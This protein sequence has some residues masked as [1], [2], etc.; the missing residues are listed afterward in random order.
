MS[1]T[2]PEAT[3]SAVVGAADQLDEVA[4]DS[5][6]GAPN[7]AVSVHV[8]DEGTLTEAPDAIDPDVTEPMVAVTADHPFFGGLAHLVLVVEQDGQ[9]VA[10]TAWHWSGHEAPKTIRAALSGLFD[11]SRAATLRFRLDGEAAGERNPIA[12]AVVEHAA[13]EAEG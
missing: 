2:P 12:E 7:P 10:E 5:D 4:S 6:T 9:K 11:T 13:T 1:D 8:P 3:S